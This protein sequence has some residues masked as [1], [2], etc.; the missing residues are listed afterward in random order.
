M[1]KLIGAVL[2]LFAATILGFYKASLYAQRSKQIRHL[3]Q[4]LQR[5]ETEIV[6]GLTPLEEAFLRL[7]NQLP[8]PIADF[9]SHAGL[10]LR[11]ASGQPASEIWR[12]TVEQHWKWTA[13]KNGEK[14]ILLGLASTLGRTDR[15]DQVKHLRLAVSQLQAEEFQA[16]DEQ[17]RYESMWKSLGVLMGALVVILMY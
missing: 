4:A 17:R 8:K 1:M 6:F 13:M 16:Q 2:V 9:F 3:I 12:Q 5:L 10:T 7:G 14:D 15:D 11:Q